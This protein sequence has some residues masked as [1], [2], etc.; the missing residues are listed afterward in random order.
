VT[1]RHEKSAKAAAT[2]ELHKAEKVDALQR[3]LAPILV[4]PDFDADYF[5]QWVGTRGRL[6]DL[7]LV[8]E[9]ACE[10]AHL[11]FAT[12]GTFA[13]LH[14]AKLIEG[15]EDAAAVAEQEALDAYPLPDGS[16][17]AWLVALAADD[18]ERKKRIGERGLE[19]A[20]KLAGEAA[21]RRQFLETIKL[22]VHNQAAAGAGSD[23]GSAVAGG[24]R[25]AADSAPAAAAGPGA[26]KRARK[27]A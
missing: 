7:P 23:A 17:W 8:A 14:E 13:A 11:A 21:V 15:V 25:A 20:A 2:K 19:A 1:R 9:R 26:A 24:K 10:I 3:A 4:K 6:D 22:A 18:D 16:R 12:D 27:A 5:A